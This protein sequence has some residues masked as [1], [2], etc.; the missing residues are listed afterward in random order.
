ME[1]VKSLFLFF[2]FKILY[3]RRWK[4][5]GIFEGLGICDVHRLVSALRPFSLFRCFALCLHE[6]FITA[7]RSIRLPIEFVNMSSSEDDEQLLDD[8]NIVGEEIDSAEEDDS[9]AGAGTASKEDSSEEDEEGDSDDE[10]DNIGEAKRTANS[11]AGETDSESEEEGSLDEDEEEASGSGSDESEERSMP[12]PPPAVQA[13]KP[14][15]GT[16]A[17]SAEASSSGKPNPPSNPEH[18]EEQE[19]EEAPDTWEG[20]GLVAPLCE[21]TRR[22]GWSTPSE[23][24]RASLVHALAG[25]DIIGLAETGSGKTGAFA[26]PIL[27]ALLAAPQRLFAVCLAPTRELAFQIHESFEGLGSGIGLSSCCVVGGVDMVT[28]AI[29][30][31]KRPHVV[32]G[33]PGRLV[34]HIENTK[35]FSLRTVP[36]PP[37][38]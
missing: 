22:L 16:K 2:A 37:P 38:P 3:A 28:Q 19:E 13:S 36:R 17:A 9:D 24:Q 30:L 5:E 26:L 11:K 27:Q 7:V 15:K 20:L 6:L 4:M 18:A 34:D 33:T 25:R 23:I 8:G 14:K 35:G 12:A 31:A 1:S 21:A 10:V 29:A 32:V